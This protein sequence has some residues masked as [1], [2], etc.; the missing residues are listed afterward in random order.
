MK[1]ENLASAGT[2]RVLQGGS[3]SGLR[4]TVPKIFRE[5]TGIEQGD[6]MEMFVDFQ[7][8]VLLQTPTE[9]VEEVNGGG[10]P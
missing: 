5:N 3:A 2:Y 4:V 9:L 1:S 10:L 8:M 7:N 6:D